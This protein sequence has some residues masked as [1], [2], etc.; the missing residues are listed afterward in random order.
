MQII[1]S[2]HLK[3][4]NAYSQNDT[5]LLYISGSLW[6]IIRLHLSIHVLNPPIMLYIS[7][8]PITNI[9]I[10]RTNKYIDTFIME[11]WI[12]HLQ[13]WLEFT[14]LPSSESIFFLSQ[15]SANN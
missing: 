15:I 8:L 9:F 3:S 7:I 12:I 14:Y 6:I 2:S 5:I 13:Y 4:H 11:H 10:L 1:I